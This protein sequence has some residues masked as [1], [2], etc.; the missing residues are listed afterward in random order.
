MDCHDLCLG[1]FGIRPRIRQWKW[2][3]NKLKAWHEQSKH[4]LKTVGG[5]DS[6]GKLLKE[7]FQDGDNK[8]FHFGD[9]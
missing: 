9:D 3:K 2:V 8:Y 1:N 6:K 4:T 5:C 7:A